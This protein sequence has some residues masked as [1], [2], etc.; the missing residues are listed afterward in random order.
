MSRAPK[1]V[2]PSLSP[3]HTL[4][5][6]IR[7]WRLLRNMS[8]EDLAPIALTD[9]SNLA[10]IE[11]AERQPSADVVERLDEALEAGG[12]LLA[13][14]AAAVDKPSSTAIPAG[15]PQW[16]A[17]AMDQLRRRLLSGIAAAGAVSA[18]SVSDGLEHLRVLLDQSVGRPGVATWEETAWEYSYMVFSPEMGDFI[19]DLSVDLLALQNSMTTMRTSETSRWLRV[20]TSMMML[21][22]Y[23]LGCA[24][25][26]RESRHWWK[27]AQRAAQQ[28]G[29]REL[30][31][32]V[33][34]R[35]AV[36]ALHEGRPVQ[37]VLSRT[38]AAL[39]LT[40]GRPS[41]ASCEAYGARAHAQ[42]LIGNAA[43]ACADIDQ[44]ARD[45]GHLPSEITSDRASVN[46]WPESRVLYT[47]SLIYTIT[48]HPNVD[49]AQQET[50]NANPAQWSRQRAQVEL[51]RAF[52]EVQRGHI[53]SGLAHANAV[54]T[55]LTSG[56]INRFVLHNAAAV[57][58]AVP[59][60]EQARP[61]VVEYRRLLALPRSEGT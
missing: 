10:K 37:L 50:I 49:T 60:M 47:R 15:R 3:W 27:S 41:V 16:D 29:D 33:Y 39:D 18:L 30:L 20:N 8:L 24:G 57:A 9:F 25:Q 1:P 7:H 46:G 6:A 35:E 11:R 21:M 12:F 31:A 51:Q 61:S 52:T 48:G 13:L 34:A 5:A 4:G 14:Y 43:D 28:T 40:R 58:M 55:R 17:E 38:T 42:S 56:H 22:A 53:D 19:R 44:Q 2:D 36:Q 54:L 59:A 23:A 26:S 45:F 32:L